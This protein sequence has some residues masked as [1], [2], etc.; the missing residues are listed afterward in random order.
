MWNP[1]KK[2]ETDVLALS[3]NLREDAVG[4]L[5]HLNDQLKESTQHAK[6]AV[7]E[8]ALNIEEFKA[9]IT[10]E[11]DRILHANSIVAAN[12]VTSLHVNLIA[13]AAAK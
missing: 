10:A 5:H 13:G 2:V 11:E 12:E 4:W 6:N 3:H 9:W 8:S 7:H 1:F